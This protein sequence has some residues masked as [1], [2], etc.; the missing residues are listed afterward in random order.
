MALSP[1]DPNSYSLPEEAVVTHV[2]LDWDVDFDK[3]VLAGHAVLKVERRKPEVEYLTLD[4]NKLD[5]R[6]AVDEAT[7][8]ALEFENNKASRLRPVL[9]TF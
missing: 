4:T 2:H 8:Q 1:S 9:K 7:G 6:S 3:K 5:V